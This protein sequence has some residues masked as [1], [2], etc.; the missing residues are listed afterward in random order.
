MKHNT[1]RNG[2]NKQDTHK[3]H[4]ATQT[5]HSEKD[6]TGKDWYENNC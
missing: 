5:K 6:N 2:I 3:P 4:H 1:A